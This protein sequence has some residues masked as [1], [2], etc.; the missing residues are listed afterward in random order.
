[1]KMF[2]K[3]LLSFFLIINNKYKS[4]RYPKLI[5]LKNVFSQPMWPQSQQGGWSGF[6]TGGQQGRQQSQLLV[7]LKQFWLHFAVV[8]PWM[9]LPIDEHLQLQGI[10]PP[11]TIARLL[12]ITSNN[13]NIKQ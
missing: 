9:H 6:K 11:L 1:M 8:V 3:K 5:Y 13:I 2:T 4:S 7:Q 10:F 12:V